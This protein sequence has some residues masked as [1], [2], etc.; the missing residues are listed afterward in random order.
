MSRYMTAASVFTISKTAL[1]VNIKRM[2]NMLLFS[3]QSLS[4]LL[5]SLS[6]TAK[7]SAGG[8]KS[9]LPIFSYSAQS[10]FRTGSYSRNSFVS[11]ATGDKTT[12]IRNALINSKN[13]NKILT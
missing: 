7:K 1:F 6:C 3:E 5:L 9:R 10:L 8:K 13:Y 4:G 11:S 12:K 2:Q